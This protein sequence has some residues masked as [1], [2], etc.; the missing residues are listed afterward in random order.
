VQRVKL[1]LYFVGFIL[2]CSLFAINLNSVNAESNSND[3]FYL[4][5]EQGQ[6]LNIDEFEYI[7]GV[8]SHEVP[9]FSY[10]IEGYDSIG[11]YFF[12]TAHSSMSESLIQIGQE[13]LWQ[14]KIP[15]SFSG[16][17]SCK[18]H[19]YQLDYNSEIL[20]EETLMMW[21]KS[22]DDV[23]IQWA[24]PIIHQSFS[25]KGT[26]TPGGPS[27]HFS[28]DLDLYADVYYPSENQAM[29]ESIEMD[30]SAN[31][32]EV[33]EV[34]ETGSNFN[35]Q[36]ILIEQTELDTRHYKLHFSMSLENYSEGA[37]ALDF[38]SDKY[39]R[40]NVGYFFEIDKTTPIPIIEA[41]DFVYE[42]LEWVYVNAT[43]SFDPA[44]S[45]DIFHQ[46][47]W[48]ELPTIENVS[49]EWIIEDPDGTISVPNENMIVSPTQLRFLPITNGEYI[50]TLIVTDNA[51]NKN[52]TSQSINVENVIPVSLISDSNNELID[53]PIFNYNRTDAEKLVF[54]A[55]LSTDST[56][57][58]ADLQFGWYLDGVLY[59]SSNVTEINVADLGSSIE[60]ELIVKDSDGASDNISITLNQIDSLMGESQKLNSNN[61]FF[62]GLNLVLLTA[63]ICTIILFF[64]KKKSNEVNPL[65]KWSEHNKKQ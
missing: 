29:N 31:I 33:A 54:C 63:F 55:D 16:D 34:S 15:V 6:I 1:R 21:L 2:T 40:W 42:S 11:N 45:L 51:G 53:N 56:N 50:F 65:P 14:W 38:N 23:E 58:I 22:D 27:L 47:W 52:Q 5:D 18:I 49:F 43:N 3:E 61:N 48:E 17:C 64:I 30:I 32:A 37:Y 28:S 26:W 59:S 8:S 46:K 57:E 25:E 39:S 19:I 20:E 10:R 7:T 12:G 24:Y 36:F 9:L 44:S 62:N 60:L 4:L 13:D 35:S 41:N